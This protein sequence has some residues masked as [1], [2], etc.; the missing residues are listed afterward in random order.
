M[1]PMR[2]W[3]VWLETKALVR[4][5]KGVSSY[6]RGDEESLKGN[7]G[8]MRLDIGRPTETENNNN[9]SLIQ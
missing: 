8:L 1:F 7:V 4:A 3:P 9:K 2:Q 5:Q 6:S